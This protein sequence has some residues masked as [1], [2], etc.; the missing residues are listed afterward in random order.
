MLTRLGASDG[1]RTHVAGVALQN[2]TVRPRPLWSV[3]SESHRPVLL[4]R[5]MPGVLGQRRLK[6]IRMSKNETWSGRGESNTRELRPK[7]SASIR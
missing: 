4:G 2:L 7:R 5:Q 6:F 1:S 3:L